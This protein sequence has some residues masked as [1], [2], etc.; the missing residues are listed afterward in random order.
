MGVTNLESGNYAR[1]RTG[2]AKRMVQV[3]V[4]WELY[5]FLLPAA[6]YFLAFQYAP[7]YGVQIAFRDYTAAGGIAGSPWAGLVHFR[8][9]FASPSFVRIVWNTIGISLYEL[10]AQFPAPILLALLINEIRLAKFK[11]VVQTVSYAPHFISTVVMVGMIILFLNPQYGVVNTFIALFGIEPVH[12]MASDRWFK[13][14]YVFSGV[15]QSTGWSSIIYLAALAGVSPDLHHAAM[16]DGASRMQRI[17]H[18][19]IPSILPI[20]SILF[21]LNAGRV[22]SVGFEKVFLMQNPLNLSSSEIIATYVYKMGILA[23]QVSFSAAVGLF[24]SVVNLALILLVNRVV[25]RL[26]ETG[27]I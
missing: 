22:M 15:W 17:R 19:N 9:F 24:N 26:T 6:L 27:L 1:P 16:I 23:H 4:N 12:F 25:K 13:T 8:R 11:R 3:L 14:I 5:I 21:I 20:I 2:I 10:V 18:I 7:I